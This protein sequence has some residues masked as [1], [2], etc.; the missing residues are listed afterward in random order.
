MIWVV[1]PFV[2][3]VQ[4]DL[5]EDGSQPTRTRGPQQRLVGDGVQRVVG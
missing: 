5:F 2:H 3:R 1:D 4:Q